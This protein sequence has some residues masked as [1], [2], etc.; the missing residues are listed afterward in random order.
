MGE[1][2]VCVPQHN[3]LQVYR[4]RSGAHTSLAKTENSEQLN[5]SP[6]LPS[7]FQLLKF[8]IAIYEL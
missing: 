7:L 4:T 5:I 1:L 2:R 8:M 6:I 3:L